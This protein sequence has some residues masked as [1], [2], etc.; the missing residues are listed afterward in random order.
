MAVKGTI[1]VIIYSQT[2]TAKAPTYQQS[3]EDCQII[4]TFDSLK[5]DS[6]VP[7]VVRQ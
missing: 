2:M 7:T 5:M 3:K 4:K 6:K 1:F